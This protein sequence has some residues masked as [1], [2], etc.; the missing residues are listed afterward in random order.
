[1]RLSVLAALLLAACRETPAPL[2]DCDGD[3]GGVWRDDQ[4]R[5]WHLWDDR[6]D[7]SPALE[8]FPMWDTSAPEGRAKT[9]PP[10][11]SPLRIRLA[12]RETGTVRQ[13]VDGC[14][15][16]RKAT[17]GACAGRRAVLRLEDG[18]AACGAPS[19]GWIQ[20]NLRR[21]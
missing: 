21:D 7:R 12:D 1:M 17:F 3:V 6:G 4:G 5:R 19:T 14:V 2:V 10:I 8:V 13:R 16:E 15:I 11:L 9:E 18:P 20:V